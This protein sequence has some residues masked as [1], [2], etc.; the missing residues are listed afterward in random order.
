MCGRAVVWFSGGV[1][2]IVAVTVLIRVHRDSVRQ[3]GFFCFEVSQGLSSTGRHAVFHER[4]RIF[5]SASRATQSMRMA[6]GPGDSP[7]QAGIPGMKVAK[8]IIRSLRKDVNF[9]QA[10]IQTCTPPTSPQSKFQ[11][12]CGLVWSGPRLSGV[13]E[14]HGRPADRIQQIG[15][16]V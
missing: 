9:P 16:D 13:L 11:P 4:K 10:V 6:K 3:R 15:V 7:F 1:V 12:D 14:Q 5:I 8:K 2:G